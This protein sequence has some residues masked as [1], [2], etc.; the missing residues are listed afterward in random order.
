MQA[1]RTKTR[2]IML[3]VVVVF[4]V[5]LFAMYITR[6]GGPSRHT[7]GERDFAVAVVDGERVMASQVVAGVRDYVQQTGQSDLSPE[8]IALMR[9]Q[10][11]QNIAL[12]HMLEKEA[13][14]QKIEPSREDID[15]AV[16]RIEKQFP[17]KEAFQ[18]Y[19]DSSGIK[20]KALQ[21]RIAAQLSQQMV[22]EA[23]TPQAEVTDEEAID[24]TRQLGRDLGLLVGVSS[25]ANVWAARQL[26]TRIKG[27]IATI[28]P[29]RAE[30]Y[31]STALL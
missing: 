1:L 29:D 12:G 13:A 14:R 4:V 17:T 2:V 30:R 16:K 7:E 3:V 23:N 15:A 11:L 18:Q 6:G 9:N 22:L 27:N 21:E 26:A 20:M 24:T 28:L 25:G 5:S 10:V 19:M 31:F 8:S